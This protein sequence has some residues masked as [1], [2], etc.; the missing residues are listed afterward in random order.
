MKIEI[1]LPETLVNEIELY[2]LLRHTSRDAV[3]NTA[4]RFQLFNLS[5]FSS[6]SK[7]L[8]KTFKSYGSTIEDR[9][10]NDEK[11]L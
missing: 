7:S 3:I 10:D 2:A 6:L 1:D 4:C 8:L 11:S 5:Y 9:S